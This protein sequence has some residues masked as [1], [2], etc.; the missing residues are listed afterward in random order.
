MPANLENSAVATGLE[1]VSFIPIQRKAMPKNDQTTAQ[2]HSSHT[3]AKIP[4]ILYLL[5]KLKH[6]L[7]QEESLGLLSGNLDWNCSYVNSRYPD[8]DRS[9]TNTESKLR[10]ALFMCKLNLRIFCILYY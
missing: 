1:K 8:L 2:L 7:I 4:A 5:L 6:I 3:L 10:T 9:L